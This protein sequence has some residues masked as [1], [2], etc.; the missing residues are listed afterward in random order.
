MLNTFMLNKIP[1]CSGSLNS[2]HSKII[3]KSAEAH[4]INTFVFIRNE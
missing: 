3:R 1:T 4:I 2:S